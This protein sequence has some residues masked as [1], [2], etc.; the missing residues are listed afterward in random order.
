MSFL[1]EL[2]ADEAAKSTFLES[3]PWTLFYD[4]GA[5]FHL[6]NGAGEKITLSAPL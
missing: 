4:G 2:R 6:A 5:E 1:E 3:G